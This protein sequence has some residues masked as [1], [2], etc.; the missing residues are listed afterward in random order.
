MTETTPALSGTK[1]KSPAAR[2]L[3]CPSFLAAMGVLGKRWNALVIQA[4]GRGASRFVDVRD[5]VEG[6]SDAVLARRLGELREWDLVERCFADRGQGVE[7]GYAHYRLTDRGQ[8]LLP[9]L[10][11]L[12]DWAERWMPVCP[13]APAGKDGRA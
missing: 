4:I 6:I 2:D 5:A 1:V 3:L 10:D 12:T 11:Q 8:A 7:A 9:A 13:Q